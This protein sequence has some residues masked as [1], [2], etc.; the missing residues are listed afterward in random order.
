M[1]H[2]E[3]IKKNEQIPFLD[4]LIIMSGNSAK[5]KVYIKLMSK[6][7]F[8]HYPSAYNLKTKS[9]IVMGFLLRALRISRPNFF[10]RN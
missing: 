3:N 9:G 6:N 8:V 1:I 7:D 2:S 4:T 5:F 10:P